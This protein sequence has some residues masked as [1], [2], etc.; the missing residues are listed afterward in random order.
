MPSPERRM[1]LGE[2]LELLSM[3]MVPVWDVPGEPPTVGVKL[4]TTVHEAPG[5]SAPGK[6]HVPPAIANAGGMAEGVSVVTVGVPVK[7]SVTL[8]GFEMVM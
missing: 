7:L 3:T 2:L 5:A 6:L 4:T 1:V 8:L